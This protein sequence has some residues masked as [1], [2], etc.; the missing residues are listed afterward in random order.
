METE[1]SFAPGKCWLEDCKELL[2]S[3]RYVVLTHILTV[4]FYVTLL[5]KNILFTYL[6]GSTGS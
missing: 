3:S 2:I 1:E 6:F 4:T 5:K